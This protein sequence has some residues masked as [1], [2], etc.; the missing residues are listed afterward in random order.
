MGEFSKTRKINIHKY[1]PFL[2]GNF[3]LGAYKAIH[4]FQVLHLALN[5]KYIKGTTYPEFEEKMPPQK[6]YKEELIFLD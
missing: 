1:F 5:A 2:P 6:N 4:M 3:H